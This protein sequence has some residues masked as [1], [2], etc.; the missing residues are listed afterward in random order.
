M[1]HMQTIFSICTAFALTG[2]VSS[3]E[4]PIADQGQS[5]A[6]TTLGTGILRLSDGT[7]AGT[8]ALSQHAHGINLRITAKNIAPGP[9]GFHLHTIGKCEAPDFASAAGHLNPEGK[10]HGS[11][12]AKGSHLGDLPNL[13]ANAAGKGS[14]ITPISGD[15][16]QTLAWIFDTDGTAVIIHADPD[17]Y[18]TNPSGAAG[19][20]IACAVLTRI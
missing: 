4:T 8:V 15:S 3:S 12:S 19:A 9:H 11:L 10:A 14:V 18:T 6:T 5:S 16:Q 17:D 2:C 7:E 13:E 20:R 1:T